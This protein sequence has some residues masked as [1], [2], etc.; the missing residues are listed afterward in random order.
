MYIYVRV[1]AHYFSYH[2]N[3]ST[4]QYVHLQTS[5][6]PPENGGKF[7][8]STSEEVVQW[9]TMHKAVRCKS[10]HKTKVRVAID[11]NSLF[12]KIATGGISA[13]L[14]ITPSNFPI[15]ILKPFLILRFNFTCYGVRLKIIKET[16]KI[17]QINWPECHRG[18][19]TAIPMSRGR[20]TQGKI[21]KNAKSLLYLKS[22]Q[23]FS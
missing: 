8:M 23:V 4:T 22:G 11:L 2:K 14:F 21:L 16:T 19:F 20:L 10:Y 3:P 12:Q 9:S 15:P 7:E 18:D 1:C 5:P 17:I 6:F 13:V